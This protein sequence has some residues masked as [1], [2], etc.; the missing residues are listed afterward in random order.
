MLVIFGNDLDHEASEQEVNV[1]AMGLPNGATPGNGV[2]MFQ[3]LLD[4]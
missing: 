4:E 3:N 1:I 2:L